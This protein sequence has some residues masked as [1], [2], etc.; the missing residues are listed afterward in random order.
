M[1]LRHPTKQHEKHPKSNKMEESETSKERRGDVESQSEDED[2]VPLTGG[3]RRRLKSRH[4]RPVPVVANNNKKSSQRQFVLVLVG[5]LSMFGA[6]LFVMMGKKV[7][8]CVAL[9]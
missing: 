1:R 7:V 8:L 6:V 9:S 3:S 2:M 5:V 4:R